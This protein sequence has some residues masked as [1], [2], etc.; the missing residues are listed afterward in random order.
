MAVVLIRSITIMD[1][2]SVTKNEYCIYN[3][4]VYMP[5]AREARVSMLDEYIKVLEVETKFGGVFYI[6]YK[7]YSGNLNI[8]FKNNIYLDLKTGNP[9]FAGV[10]EDNICKNISDIDFKRMYNDIYLNGPLP[11]FL[12]SKYKYDCGFRNYVDYLDSIFCDTYKGVI[13]NFIGKGI[14][15]LFTN[16]PTIFVGSRVTLCS[17]EEKAYRNT[18]RDDYFIVESING[19]EFKVLGDDNTYNICDICSVDNSDFFINVMTE[20]FNFN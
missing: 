2:I 8:N 10:D 16:A 4:T 17:E 11:V 13:D 6:P 5:I 12:M 18:D 15:G 7:E 20:N 14:T 9:T 19:T 1:N 3:D